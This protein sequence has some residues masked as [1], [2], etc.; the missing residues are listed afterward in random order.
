MYYEN[1]TQST[2]KEVEESAKKI[3]FNFKKRKKS[4]TNY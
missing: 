4:A 1:R 3:K 2:Q